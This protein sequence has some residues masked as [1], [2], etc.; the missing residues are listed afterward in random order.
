MEVILKLPTSDSLLKD[1]V[2]GSA[3][4]LEAS[5]VP[6]H[7]CTYLKFYMYTEGKQICYFLVCDYVILR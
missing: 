7:M 3:Q 2:L 6:T 4:I 5:K 1:K